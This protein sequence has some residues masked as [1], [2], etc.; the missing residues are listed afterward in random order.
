[1]VI[2]M[3]NLNY[4][5]IFSRLDEEKMKGVKNMILF[6]LSRFLRYSRLCYFFTL[7]VGDCKIQFSPLAIPTSLFVNGDLEPETT[8]FLQKKL[9]KADVYID[10]GANVGTTTLVAAKAVGENGIVFCF[11]P[12][13]RTYKALTVNI[14]KNKFSNILAKQCALGHKEGVVSFS[15]KNNDDMNRVG[16]DGEGRVVKLATLDSFL[17][18]INDIRLIKIDVE[19]YEINVLQGATETLNKTDMVFFETIEDNAKNYGFKVRDL[20]AFLKLH[21]FR[22]M[23]TNIAKEYQGNEDPSSYP[24]NLVAVNTRRNINS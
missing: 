21:N 8:I 6:L 13:E 19:G 2:H 5:R 24:Y 17:G 1:M 7:S 3:L 16:I 23:D 9:R 18:H 11:E 10:I 22:I 4:K 15:D 14:S 12:N 20:I